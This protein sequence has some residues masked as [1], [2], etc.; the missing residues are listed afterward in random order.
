MELRHRGHRMIWGVLGSVLLTIA[1]TY[2]MTRSPLPGA[3]GGSGPLSAQGLYQQAAQE[4]RRGDLA[5]TERHLRMALGVITG[6]AASANDRRWEFS[7]RSSLAALVAAR[8]ERQQA[9]DIAAPACRM[10]ADGAPPESLITA[11]LC[12]R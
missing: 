2:S 3:E 1:V 5:A 11:G 8:G 6:P 10:G 4:R 7:V 9:R 12:D